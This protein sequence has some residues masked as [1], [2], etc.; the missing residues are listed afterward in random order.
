MITT[1]PMAE[2]SKT[3]VNNNSLD[4]EGNILEAKVN[5]YK[6]EAIKN[7]NFS[8]VIKPAIISF[9]ALFISFFLDLSSV[10]I[11]GNITAKIAKSLFPNW[12]ANPEAL[13]PYS[14]WWIPVVIY[15]LFF[16]LAL[17][18]FNKLKIEVIS[19]YFAHLSSYYL[20]PFYYSAKIQ[21]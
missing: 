17:S 14:F 10:P 18:L 4:S 19:F 12:Q 7:L 8:V 16:A 1:E 21:I 2:K 9:A 6:N 13:V 3:V 15:V 5:A 11:L 20:N